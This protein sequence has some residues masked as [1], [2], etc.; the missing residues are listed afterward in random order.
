MTAV[1]RPVMTE[2][3]YL[4]YDLAHEGKHEFYDGQIVAREAASEAHALVTMNIG[5]ALRAGLRGKPCRVYSAD[6]RV[7]TEDTGAY[8]YPDVTIVCGPSELRPTNPPSLTNP[9]LVVEVLSP[10]TAAH[11]R[12]PKAAHY[13]RIPTLGAY[14]I[15]DIES[16]R[17]E[18]YHR[19]E[20]GI[21]RL[22]EGQGEGEILVL[23]LNVTLALAEAWE[24]LDQIE[25][26]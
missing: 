10:S 4:A 8:V 5:A 14:M 23:P 16:R 9:K 22:T 26:G 25:E 6:L 7:W 17:I 1:R 15:V 20:D 11:D 2:A 21:F 13:R 19:G 12:G 24:G 18:V 3:E